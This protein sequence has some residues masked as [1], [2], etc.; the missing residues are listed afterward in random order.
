MKLL[1]I[2]TAG[3]VLATGSAFGATVYVSTTGFGGGAVLGNPVHTV[4]VGAANFDLHFYF[5][6]D[7][8]DAPF[9]GISVNAALTVG[10]V[11]DFVGLSVLAPD[12]VVTAVPTIVTDSRWDGTGGTVT[13]PILI[14]N[15]SGVAVTTAGLDVANDGSGALLDEG[16][17]SSAGA[18]YFGSVTLDPLGVGTTVLSL[19]NGPIGTARVG[20]VPRPTGP[21]ASLI[22]GDLEATT[23]FGDD[24]GGTGTTIDATINV[25]PEPSSFFLIGAGMLLSCLRRRR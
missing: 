3:I 5:I 13:S 11:A 8:G 2:L 23:V 18:F 14:T 24:F 25:V 12:V 10:G 22:Y 7:P 21:V 4:D 6:P 16:Y 17:D 20:D 19:S 15:M 1:R 9:V